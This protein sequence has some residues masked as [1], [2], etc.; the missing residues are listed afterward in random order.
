[1]TKASLVSSSACALLLAATAAV[2]YRWWGWHTG[3]QETDRHKGRGKTGVKTGVVSLI[4]NT[5][6][7]RINSLSDHTGC[8]ILGKA[9]FLNPGGS[10]KDRIA[11]YLIEKA[12]TLGLLTPNTQSC[13]FEGTSGSTGISLAMVAR[14]KGYLCHI[15]MPSDQAIEKSQLL[16]RFGATV[17]RV[18]PC[19][20]VDRNNFVNVARRRAE[21]Y[22]GDD[23]A[24]RKKGYFVDQFENPLNSEAH[25]RTTGP[26]IFAQANGL[27][28]VFVHGSG[29]GGTIAGVTRYL[30]PRVPRLQCFLADP[31]GSGLANKINHG[32]MFADTEREGTRRRQQVDTLVEGVGLNRMTRN[33]ANLLLPSGIHKKCLLDGALSVSDA[34]AVR[35]SRW[36]MANDGLFVGSSAAINCVA[37][38]SIARKMGPG[39][40]IVTILADSGQRHLTKFWNDQAM[41]SL[42]HPTEAP[43]SLDEFDQLI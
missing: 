43:L 1:M 39:H 17:E 36:L 19:S 8:E 4:G 3:D 27:I 2:I 26:E 28:D 20:I 40:T 21:E 29:T 10:S 7:I 15:V 16:E 32:V 5:P 12:E 37:A 23:E 35:M 13:I 30:K 22:G 18:A 14:A 38:L 24:G 25:Y 42:G 31:Q 11:L 34:D 6:L 33:F 41:A 9:E